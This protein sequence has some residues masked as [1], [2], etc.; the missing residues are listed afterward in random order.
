MKNLIVCA[1]N[2][3]S[4]SFAKSIGIGL[5]NSSITL[6]NICKIAKPQ[7]IIFIGTCGLYKDGKILDIYESSH[8]FNIEAGK[9]LADFY[10]PLDYEIN[11]N[12]SYETFRCNSSNYICVNKNIAYKFFELGLSLENMEAFAV[13]NVA[14]YFDIKA[15]CFL[16]ATNFC[17]E[18]AHKDFV[19]NHALAK[20]KLENFLQEKNII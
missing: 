9:I 2:N 12:V 1:G 17:D 13:L 20:I 6:S 5:I 11:L 10:T 16:C 3:E 8:A 7:K 15:T 4:F 18:N 14:K 19:K